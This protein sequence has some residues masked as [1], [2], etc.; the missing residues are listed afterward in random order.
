MGI[1]TASVRGHCQLEQRRV[2]MSS[3]QREIFRCGPP[4]LWDLW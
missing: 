2:K 3:K 1:F 4:N